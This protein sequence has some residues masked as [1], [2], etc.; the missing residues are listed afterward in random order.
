VSWAVDEDVPGSK[1]GNYVH[2]PKGCVYGHNSAVFEKAP[3]AVV[4]SPRRNEP[5]ASDGHET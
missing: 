2:R 1:H 4:Q 3:L 5:G